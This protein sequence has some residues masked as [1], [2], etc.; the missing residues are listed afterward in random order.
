MGALPKEDFLRRLGGGTSK[1]AEPV[2]RPKPNTLSTAKLIADKPTE[3][4]LGG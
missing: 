1:I 4:N 3:F 2:P